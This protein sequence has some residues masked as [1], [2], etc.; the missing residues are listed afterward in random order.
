VDKARENVTVYLFLAFNGDNNQCLCIMPQDLKKVLN[1]TFYLSILPN[2]SC[3]RY[4]DNRRSDSNVKNKFKCGSS[5]DSRIW[6]IYNLNITCPIDSFYIQELKECIYP[7]RGFSDSCPSSSVNYVYD[8]NINWN[9]FLKAIEKL[10]LTDSNVDIDFDVDVTIEP[11]WKCSTTETAYKKDSNEYDST[12][13]TRTIRSYYVLNNGCLRL[14]PRS[15][16]YSYSY[17]YSFYQHGI[18]NRLCIPNRVN[19]RSS[20]DYTEYYRSY[21]D[22]FDSTWDKCPPRWLDINKNC[23]QISK[24]RKTIQEAKNRCINFSE[25]DITYTRGSFILPYR[26]ND[27]DDIDDDK[28]EMVDTSK[29]IMNDFLKGEIVQYTSQWE[30]RLGFFL[31]DKSKVFKRNRID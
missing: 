22:T 10:K 5:T 21:G 30:V 27:D 19:E 25:P 24:D 9:I 13:Y 8:G 26:S 1:N 28:D 6:A 12:S 16:S 15:Y 17:S 3:D 23:Y 2:N 4:C 29:R 11:A 31:L 14:R 18:R 20:S 7:Y